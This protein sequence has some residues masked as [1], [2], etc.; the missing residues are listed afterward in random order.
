MN[1][2]EALA[3]AEKLELAG[4]DDWRLPSVKELQSIVDYSKAPDADD[5][6]KRAPAIDPVFKLSEKESWFWTGTTHIENQFAYYVCFGQAFSARKQAGKQ[7][8]AHGAG[9]VRSDPKEGD[10]KKWPDGLGPQADEI[11]V[12]NYVRCV[13]GGKVTLRR[14]GPAVEDGGEQKPESRF[15]RRLDKDGDGRV[16]RQEFDGPPRAFDRHDKNGD[17]YLD[18]DEA[19]QRP[20]GRGGRRQAPPGDQPEQ[21]TEEDFYVITVGTSGPTYNPDRTRAA[22][23]VKYGT[24]YI[25]VD[26]GEGTARHLSRESINYKNIAAYC[27]THHHRDHNADAMSILPQAWSREFI[28]P[29]IGPKGTKKLVDFL[30]EFYRE[31]LEYRLGNKGS[32]FE[33][34]PRPEVHELPLKKSLEIAGMKITA[35]EVPHTITTYALRFE[36]DEKAI[37]ISG[38]LTYSENLIKL[39]NDADILVMDSGGIVYKSGGSGRKRETDRPHET[40]RPRGTGAGKRGKKQRAHTTLEEVAKM[41]AGANVKK[42]VLTHFGPG[43]VDEEETLRR[44]REIYSGEVVFAEDMQVHR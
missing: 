11:R 30:R 34:L 5:R 12:N 3:C 15:I 42:L 41:A 35:A 19:P 1:W 27:F 16:S 40:D 17:G 14:E 44:I 25:L 18:A 29:V 43:E 37:V 20:G 33:K 7:I 31:D 8:N 9:A 10:P 23:L 2:K 32:S 21:G 6:K 28:S 39:A 24:S 13:R 38:D 22:N 36:A 26:M 4:K